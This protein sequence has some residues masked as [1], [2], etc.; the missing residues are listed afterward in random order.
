MTTYRSVLLRLINVLD[1]SCEENRNIHYIFN[2]LRDNVEE[3]GRARQATDDNIIRFMDFACWITKA[4]GTQSEYV[5]LIAFPRLYWLCELFS[6]LSWTYI[7]ILVARYVS[8]LRTIL[9]SSTSDNGSW[10]SNLPWSCRQK[11]TTKF[12]TSLQVNMAL[13]HRKMLW[14]LSSLTKDLMARCFQFFHVPC[15]F[16]PSTHMYGS[17]EFD[18]PSVPDQ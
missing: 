3:Y 14:N 6:I 9:L 5:T 18:I 16:P 15:V 13:P 1:K 7:E 12:G 17:W 2:N 8:M 11:N 10:E 4:T